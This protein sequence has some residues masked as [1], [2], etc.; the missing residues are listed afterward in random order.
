[1]PIKQIGVIANIGIKIKNQIN[2]ILFFWNFI[3][4]IKFL[5]PVIKK[6]APEEPGYTVIKP[7]IILP[8]K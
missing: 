4:T 8:A 2:C 3:D 5:F 1:M 7:L 6:P